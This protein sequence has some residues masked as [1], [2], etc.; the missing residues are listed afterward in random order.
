MPLQA[1]TQAGARRA[2]TGDLTPMT[3]ITVPP[4]PAGRTGW[5]KTVSALTVG[6]G[7]KQVI[8][9]WLQSGDDVDVP[10]GTLVVV[11]DKTLVGFKQP[12][13]GGKPVYEVD[14]A[15]CLVDDAGLTSLWGRH[16]KT[17]S[18]AF[19]A[20]TRKRLV[21]L[22]AEHPAP[23]VPPR[24]VAEARRP[25]RRDGD[26]RRCGSRIPAWKGHVVGHGAD[27]AVEHWRSCTR[28]RAST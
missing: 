12:A 22:L 21:A 14:V 13:G 25:N 24:V 15:V 8:G 23:A 9:E 27:A 2:E 28:V 20:T 10:S 6:R 7:G 17:A 19:G 5:R 1:A 4:L 11:V 3:R 18:L 16:F 26:C